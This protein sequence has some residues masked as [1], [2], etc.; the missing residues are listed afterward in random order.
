MRIALEDR[1]CSPNPSK[2]M[3]LRQLVDVLIASE[4]W[5][6]VHNGYEVEIG[7]FMAAAY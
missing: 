5:L 1:A 6:S 2:S 4:S 7:L 3:T